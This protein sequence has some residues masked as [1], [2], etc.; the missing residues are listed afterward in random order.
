MKRERGREKPP[1]VVVL[2]CRVPGGG[3]RAER[4]A[5]ERR[6]RAAVAAARACGAELVVASG[7]RSWEG[8]VEAD[9]MRARLV[10]LGV[11]EAMVIRE[12]L[13]HTTR[14]NAAFVAELLDRRGVREVVI[15][16]CA[17]HLPRALQLFRARG[18]EAIGHAA[19]DDAASWLLRRY[20]G[21]RERVAARLDGARS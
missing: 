8:V 2:G 15:V 14:E 21:V 16:S 11:A 18:L 20:R 13:S 3:A 12:R 9:A 6:V 1:A 5:L 7:G 4:S 19:E 10:A 17:W